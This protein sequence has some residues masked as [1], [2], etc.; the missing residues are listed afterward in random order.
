MPSRSENSPNTAPSSPPCIKTQ[1]DNR[2]N[3][4]RNRR[5]Q[6][7]Y[8]LPYNGAVQIAR[9]PALEPIRR[10]LF[11]EFHGDVQNQNVVRELFPDPDGLPRPDLKALS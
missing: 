3:R 11:E 10:R 8:N 2:A 1:R 4:Y 9:G 5:R 6:G 7:L